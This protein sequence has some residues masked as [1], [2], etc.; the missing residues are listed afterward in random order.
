[1]AAIYT[2]PFLFMKKGDKVTWKWG[3][4]AAEG[5]IVKKHTQPVDKTING[6]HVKRNADHDEPAYEIKQED[7][8]RVLKSQSEI[9]KD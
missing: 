2:W 6:A 7:G 8:G 9:R 3:K 1:M 5:D 4:G